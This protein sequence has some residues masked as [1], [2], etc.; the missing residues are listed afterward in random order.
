VAVLIFG[1]LLSPSI[2]LG[3][4]DETLDCTGDVVAGY[5]AAAAQIGAVLATGDQVYYQAS[6]S[7]IVLLYLPG[8]G[9]YP[10][11][12]NNV[13]SF[14][15]LNGAAIS[16]ELLRYGYWNADLKAQWLAEADFALVEARFYEG[17]WQA[18][19]EAGDYDIRLVTEV[20]EEC[21]GKDS[22]IMLLERR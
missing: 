4:G 20:V 13:F 18:A 12:L 21:R 14:S 9:I 19:V 17:E 15:D 8:I 5:E 22:Q 16:D 10:P 7:P 3:G 6:N 1:I 11:Q 2:L